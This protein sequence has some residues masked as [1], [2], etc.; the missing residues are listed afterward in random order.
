MEQPNYYLPIMPYLIV[1]GANEF[2]EFTDKVFG[3]IVQLTVPR[4]EGVIMH[5]E[6]TIGKATVM[7]A[8]ATETYQPF[9]GGMFLFVEDVKKTYELGLA[10]GAVS[11]LEVG[12]REYGL[13]AGLKD[14]FGN[15]WWLAQGT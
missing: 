14:P 7:F 1:E 12:E 3:A 6:I 11:A 15:V 4:S 5:G 2:I 13:S 9:P 10:N 8:D